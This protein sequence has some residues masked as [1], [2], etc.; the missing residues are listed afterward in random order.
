MMLRD[1]AEEKPAE[2]REV[3]VV[4]GD[5]P[6]GA[7]GYILHGEWWL[8]V[9]GPDPMLSETVVGWREIEAGDP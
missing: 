2:G 6:F 9:P 7:R 4:Y 1:P 3:W 5:P 8:S